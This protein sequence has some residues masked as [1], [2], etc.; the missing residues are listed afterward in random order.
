VEKG[1]RG[2]YPGNRSQTHNLSA[3]FFIIHII[4][5]KLTV[6]VRSLILFVLCGGPGATTPVVPPYMKP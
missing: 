6:S 5:Y 4:K 3:F 1:R 2:S